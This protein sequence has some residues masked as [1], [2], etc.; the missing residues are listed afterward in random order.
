[1]KGANLKETKE[2][3]DKIVDNDIM[4]QYCAGMLMEFEPRGHLSV[5]VVLFRERLWL[6]RGVSMQQMAPMRMN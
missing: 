3:E 5:L 2:R 6:S 1:M 4:V